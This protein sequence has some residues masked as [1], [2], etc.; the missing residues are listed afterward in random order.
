VRAGRIRAS[1]T[2]PA[3]AVRDVIAE[4]QNNEAPG[5]DEFERQRT[6]RPARSRPTG[7][8]IRVCRATAMGHAVSIRQILVPLQVFAPTS[9]AI[10]DPVCLSVSN[11]KDL[12]YMF[13]GG[14]ATFR[15]LFLAR[16]L[17]RRF[18]G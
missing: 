17:V 2:G 4:Q 1:G 12:V 18:L 15:N 3:N 14:R 5:N 10:S 11:Y 9:A 8:L 13:L 6:K 16:K 7:L